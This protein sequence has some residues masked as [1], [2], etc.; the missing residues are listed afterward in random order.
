MQVKGTIYRSFF[1]GQILEILSI[2]NP[3]V[4]DKVL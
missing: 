2:K 4:I 1:Y 3:E